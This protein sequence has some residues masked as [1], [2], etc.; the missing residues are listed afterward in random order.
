MSIAHVMGC[1]TAAIFFV[2]QFPLVFDPNGPNVS[3]GWWFQGFTFQK[4]LDC[5]R[6]WINKLS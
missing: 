6:V 1:T 3:I 5:G 2:K 4:L